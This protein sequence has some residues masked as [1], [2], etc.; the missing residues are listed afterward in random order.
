MSQTFILPAEDRDPVL[1]RMGAFCMR[2]W[3]G[4][5][6]KVTVELYRKKRSLEQNSY[7]WGVVYPTMLR[8][9][10]DGWTA[11]DIHEL[12]LGEWGGWEVIDLYG[13]KRKRP[14]RRSSKLN[15]TDFTDFV[16]YIQQFAAEQGIYI[17]DPNEVA[18]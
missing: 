4:Q 8:E 17:P 16:A 12:M 11:D 14:K 1:V 13:Q 3:P 7:L 9:G 6:V 15:T 10:G 5:R 2:A 18:A